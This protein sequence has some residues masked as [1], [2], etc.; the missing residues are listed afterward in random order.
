MDWAMRAVLSHATSM[1]WA[2]RAA[3]SHINY[4]RLSHINGPAT[5]TQLVVLPD[6]GTVLR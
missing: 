5:A 4:V 2:M 1:D 3:L 6:P